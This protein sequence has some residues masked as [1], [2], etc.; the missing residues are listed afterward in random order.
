MQ[1]WHQCSAAQPPWLISRLLGRDGRR[2]VWPE[3]HSE[4]E[5]SIA[6]DV[7]GTLSFV[8]VAAKSSMRRVLA[9]YSVLN[10]SLAPSP[11]VP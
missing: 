4:R 6:T 5:S 2:A 11:S 7:N 10:L 3:K 1:G 8:F 9:T